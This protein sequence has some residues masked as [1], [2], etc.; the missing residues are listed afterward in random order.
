VT[1]SDSAK[2]PKPLRLMAFCLDVY[3]A[4]Q[5]KCS[6]ECGGPLKRFVMAKVYDG[7]S[8]RVG[9]MPTNYRKRPL[10][11]QWQSLADSVG[12]E[13]IRGKKGETIDAILS[14]GYMR[15]K[16]KTRKAT[17]KFIELL[18]EF[19]GGVADARLY[20]HYCWN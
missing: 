8:V 1:S 9:I 14:R 2:M 20:R 7:Y 6:R 13:G 12:P 10:L 11:R 16:F 3:L 18:N 5:L 4:G 19:W 17:E 15:V